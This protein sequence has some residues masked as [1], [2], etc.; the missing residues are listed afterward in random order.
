MISLKRMT[1][2]L[3]LAALLLGSTTAVA[4]SEMQEQND[5]NI[6][7]LMWRG[8]PGRKHERALGQAS[9]SMGYL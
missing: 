9:L 6:A 1:A 8:I 5:K 3:V 7:T 2:C 4:E